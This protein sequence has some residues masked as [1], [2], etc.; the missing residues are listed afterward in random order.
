MAKVQSFPTHLVFTDANVAQS[1]VYR[2][3]PVDLTK[4][5]QYLARIRITLD[6]QSGPARIRLF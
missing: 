2:T 3:G 5:A 6:Q 4:S 1:H